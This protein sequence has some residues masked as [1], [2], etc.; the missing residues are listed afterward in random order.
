M[1]LERRRMKKYH[2]RRSRQ[3]VKLQ[4]QQLIDLEHMLSMA[5]GTF[6]VLNEEGSKEQATIAMQKAKTELL[7][8]GPDMKKLGEHMGG[9]YPHMVNLFLDCMDSLLHSPMVDEAKVTA[10]YQAAEKLEKQLA[11]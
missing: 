8:F 1:T 3:T 11:A 4:K 6:L 7:K 10:C 5:L 2:P 9:V